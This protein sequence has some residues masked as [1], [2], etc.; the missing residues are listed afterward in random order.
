MTPPPPPT[1][2]RKLGSRFALLAGGRV[3]VLV[4]GLLATA[5]LTRLLGP[6]G[7][8][9][10]RTAVAFLGIAVAAADLGLASLFVREISQS[11]ADQRRLIGNALAL[12]LLLAAIAM[13]IAVGVAFVVPQAEDRLGILGGRSNPSSARPSRI[14]SSSSAPTHRPA[15]RK[16]SVAPSPPGIPAFVARSRLGLVGTDLLG[17]DSAQ[18]ATRFRAA[19]LQPH[20]CYEVMGLFRRSELEASVLLESFHGADRALAA[21]MALRGR[22]VHAQPLLLV[23]DHAQRYTRAR[24]RPQDRAVWHDTRLQGRRAFPTWRLYG[25]YWSIVGRSQAPLQ[26]RA[27]AALSLRNG[28]S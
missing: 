22:I 24:T 23:R 18:P 9:H 3:A 7:F 20:N 8:G 10:F 4:L 1:L 28:G 19:T 17:A 25:K 5:L 16:R 14:S 15:P 6:D 11:G 27:R 21:D 13:A 2:A 26:Q 12:R